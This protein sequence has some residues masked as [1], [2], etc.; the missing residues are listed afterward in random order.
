MDRYTVDSMDPYDMEL[1]AEGIWVMFD[2][3]QV[4]ID[5]AVSA[6]RERWRL[7]LSMEHDFAGMCPDNSNTYEMRDPDCKVCR[8]LIRIEGPNV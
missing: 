1:S 8:R 5:A 2:D 6:E 4:A 7:I 3:V